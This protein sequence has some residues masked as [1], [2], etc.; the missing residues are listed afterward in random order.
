MKRYCQTLTFVVNEEMIQKYVEAHAH[1]WPPSSDWQSGK[2]TSPSSRAA[3]LAPA[4]T[5]SDN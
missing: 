1:I 5:R 4:S 2:P 3:V